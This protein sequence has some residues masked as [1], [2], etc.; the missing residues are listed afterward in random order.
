MNVRHPETVTEEIQKCEVMYDF[1]SLEVPQWLPSCVGCGV[2]T[3]LARRCALFDKCGNT[4]PPCNKFP[5]EETSDAQFG[6]G[7]GVMDTLVIFGK[8]MYQ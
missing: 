2:S 8:S 5:D 3:H 6:D 7:V 4:K 1:F